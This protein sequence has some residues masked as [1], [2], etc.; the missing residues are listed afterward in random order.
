[1]RAG[2]RK[3]CK[4]LLQRLADPSSEVRRWAARDLADCI[5][6]AAGMVERL[7]VEPDASVREVI[8]TT[9]THLGDASAVQA[10]VEFLRSEDVALRNEAIEVMKQLPTAVAP[11]MRCLL[12]D[13]D[14][15]VRI[16]AVNIL[17]SLRHTDV[18]RWLAEV[19]AQ[20]AHVNVCATAVDLL[21]EVGSRAALEPLQN[22]KERFAEEPYIQFA[23]DL[24]IK[25]ILES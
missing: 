23:A 14:S 6:C 21:G 17:E 25:R 5:D 11:I 3:D 15:D 9:L 4:L 16:F 7:R 24:A 12:R 10:M 18:E 19:I 1:M 13:A 22:L 2:D 8:F 20:D